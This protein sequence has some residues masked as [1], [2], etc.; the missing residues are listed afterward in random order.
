M[1]AH[2]FSVPVPRTTGSQ[3]ARQG[4]VVV[5]VTTR[6]GRAGWSA[7][8]ALTAENPKGPLGNYGLMTGYAALNWVADNIKEFGGDPK[9][10]TIF[11]EQPAGAFPS[12]T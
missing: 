7:H 12:T 6:L 9:N 1:A 4:V 11:G 5:T 3:F 8:P 10:V 2:F